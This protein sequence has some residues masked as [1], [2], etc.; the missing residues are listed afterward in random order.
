MPCTNSTLEALIDAAH[1]AIAVRR[2]VPP[3]RPK[4]QPE[5]ERIYAW[6]TSLD[7]S[8]RG[9]ARRYFGPGWSD[10]EPAHCWTNG[11]SAELHLPVTP[12]EGTDLILTALLN[13]HVS[14]RTTAQ[15]VRVSVNGNPTGQWLVRNPGP[16]YITVFERHFAGKDRLTL[17]FDL[18]RAFSPQAHDLSA[19]PRVLALAFQSLSLCPVK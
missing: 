10:P 19:D 17:H 16:Q 2:G 1:A 7:F 6:G 14:T 3:P 5:N 8:T 4:Q 13:P 18:P 11:N 9:N 12:V 15:L